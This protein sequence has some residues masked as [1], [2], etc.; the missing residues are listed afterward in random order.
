MV[1]PIYFFLKQILR[2]LFSEW[3]QLSYTFDLLIE[4]IS[5]WTAALIRL[6]LY[7]VHEGISLS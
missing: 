5:I 7:K 1:H 4:V 6:N 2:E 3:E